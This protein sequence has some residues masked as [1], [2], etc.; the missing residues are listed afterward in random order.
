MS[1]QFTQIPV[2]EGQRVAVD[3]AGG[4]TDQEGTACI[5]QDVFFENAE[6]A[7]WVDRASFYADSGVPVHLVTKS[8]ADLGF[9]LF[10]PIAGC[11][12]LSVCSSGRVYVWS[13]HRER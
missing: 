12:E 4:E 2:E 13:I 5:H 10:N 7:G 9:Q 11:E 8:V 3:L 6:I 1:V